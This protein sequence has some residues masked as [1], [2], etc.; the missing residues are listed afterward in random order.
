MLLLRHSCKRTEWP[1]LLASFKIL[2]QYAA[3]GMIFDDLT[4]NVMQ[5]SQQVRELMG[6]PREDPI[7]AVTDLVRGFV[8]LLGDL[9]DCRVC[10]RWILLP[11][12]CSAHR[13]A[14]ASH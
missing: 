6:S 3:D 14:H 7:L 1:N 4:E 9:Y 13:T 10:V 8:V 2:M 11:V 12:R 5:L